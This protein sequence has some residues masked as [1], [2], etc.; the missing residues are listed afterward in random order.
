M[1]LL[2]ICDIVK[3]MPEDCYGTKTMPLLGDC[4]S[5]ILMNI[6]SMGRMILT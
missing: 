2:P 1:G 4:L 6:R 3:K 5:K